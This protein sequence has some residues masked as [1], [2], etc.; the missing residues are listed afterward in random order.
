MR[1]QRRDEHG[2]PEE[3]ARGKPLY[4]DRYVFS[5]VPQW[6]HFEAQQRV[7]AEK[8]DAKI[9]AARKYPILLDVT[10]L[11][12]WWLP[13]AKQGGV[14]HCE[15]VPA[16]RQVLPLGC[17]WRALRFAGEIRDATGG[18]VAIANSSEELAVLR[19]VTGAGGGLCFTS[20]G[21]HDDQLSPEEFFVL[22]QVERSARLE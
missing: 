15:V 16:L 14:V 22:L 6:R 3:D 7:L 2:I 18:V 12:S 1:C 20:V 21:N 10:A 17:V 9:H 5:Y 4:D 13:G 8:A 11:R 19:Q